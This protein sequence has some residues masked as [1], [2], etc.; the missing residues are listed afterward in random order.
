[1]HESQDAA[2]RDPAAARGEG[3]RRDELLLIGALA[4]GFLVLRRLLR[5]A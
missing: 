4:L 1:M 5:L 3:Q 2:A